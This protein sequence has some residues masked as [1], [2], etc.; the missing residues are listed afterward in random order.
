[1][2]ISLP[3]QDEQ[4]TDRR[5]YDHFVPPLFIAKIEL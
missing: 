4:K 2:D 3:P 1:M 5:R